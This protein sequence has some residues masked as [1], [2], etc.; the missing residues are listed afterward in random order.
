[1]SIEALAMAG[2]DYN[3]CGIDLREWER[4]NDGVEDPPPPYMLA[5]DDVGGDW[6][7]YDIDYFRKKSSAAADRDDLYYMKVKVL[8]WVKA[9]F[10]CL[11]L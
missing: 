5:D 10:Q 4:I 3:E 6:Q 1:M 8:E 11:R 2:A 9:V 7:S